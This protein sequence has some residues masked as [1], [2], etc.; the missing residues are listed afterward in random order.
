MWT[1]VVGGSIQRAAMS[2][3]T[4]SD[5]S[6]A[7]AMPNHRTQDRRTSF[8]CEIGGGMFGAGVAV[9]SGFSITLQNNRLGG[10]D[11]ARDSRPER[12]RS[13]QHHVTKRQETR[14]LKNR[15]AQLDVNEHQA[16]CSF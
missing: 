5:Q 3:S 7:S 2:M 6:S 11:I 12:N 15:T 4:A 10:F 14:S 9:A 1:A 16:E 8:Q 13:M